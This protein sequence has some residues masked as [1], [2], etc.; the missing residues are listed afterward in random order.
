[1]ARPR[2]AAEEERVT[3]RLFAS[4]VAG[5]FLLASSLPG[6]RALRRPED[7]ACGVDV[8]GNGGY[9]YAGGQATV[10]GHGVSATMILLLACYR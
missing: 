2:P 9:S 8:A 5:A 10:R 6:S 7:G 3:V 1:M 4:V